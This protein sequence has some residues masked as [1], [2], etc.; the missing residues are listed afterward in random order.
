MG[1]F[2]ISLPVKIL[3]WMVVAI[4]VGLNIKLVIAEVTN[5]MNE[6]VS[7]ILLYGLIF[8][9]LGFV[10]ALLVYTILLPLINKHKTKTIHLHQDLNLDTL[11]PKQYKRIGL[12]IDFSGME[13]KII[14]T[15]LSLGTK[16]TTYYLI[17]IVESAAARLWDA[18]SLD[19]ETEQDIQML[20]KAQKFLA[21]KGYKAEIKIGYGKPPNEIAKIAKAE[22]FD[23]LI[24]G[25]HGHQWF[26][27]ILFGATIDRLRH[28]IDIPVFIVN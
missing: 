26:K 21:N 5:W 15:A 10:F 23:L 6:G 19:S 1:K 16:E 13:N 7:P 20:K 22:Q 12:A 25:S 3:S 14:S 27:D 11:V 17:H 9:L 8:P 2:V 4:I 28:L 24:V 18:S